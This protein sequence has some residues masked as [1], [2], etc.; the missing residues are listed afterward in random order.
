MRRLARL[1]LPALLATIAVPAAA[2]DRSM[3]P[4]T[5]GER[6]NVAGY[7]R[8]EFREV[9]VSLG[10]QADG[11]MLQVFAS[12]AT[13]TWTMVSTT[14]NGTSCIVAVGEAWQILPTGPLAEIL[15]D[16]KPRP[17]G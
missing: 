11:R 16:S 3:P 7:L 17:R 10:L 14:A 13:G 9:P 1:A 8:E 4:S 5:C 6:E 2:Q 15:G 12:E